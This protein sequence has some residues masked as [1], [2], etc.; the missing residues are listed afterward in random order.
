MINDSIISMYNIESDTQFGP[1]SWHVVD[2]V[3]TKY[4]SHESMDKYW[5]VNWRIPRIILD[6]KYNW[7]QLALQY[8]ND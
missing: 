4:Y 1:F 8:S 6:D 2:Y 5:S 7:I 3:T